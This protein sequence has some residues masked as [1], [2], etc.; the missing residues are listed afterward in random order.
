[1]YR[2]CLIICRCN[3]LDCHS[4]E[5]EMVHFYSWVWSYISCIKIWCWLYLEYKWCISPNIVLNQQYAWIWKYFYLLL[6]MCHKQDEI[7]CSYFLF[8][9]GAW[10]RNRRCGGD[11]VPAI[12]WEC[13]MN[14]PIFSVHVTVYN[15][16]IPY[17]AQSHLIL[18]MP[19]YIVLSILRAPS[20]TN[21]VKSISHFFH[22]YSEI[23][24]GQ[25]SSHCDVVHCIS[26]VLVCF[27][28]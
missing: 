11:R 15:T 26:S 14:R 10:R 24:P 1:M 23:Q 22:I 17:S 20:P 21:K 6:V 28:S 18:K 5:L 13:T 8:T 27:D 12:V 19:A 7:N 2:T 9:V 3:G 25:N 4:S 16:D